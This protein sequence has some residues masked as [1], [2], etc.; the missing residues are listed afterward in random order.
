MLQLEISLNNSGQTKNQLPL[1]EVVMI[2]V[3]LEL[4]NYWEERAMKKDRKT[5]RKN[6]KFGKTMIKMNIMKFNRTQP[7]VEMDMN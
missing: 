3:K 4:N 1:K 2:H 7:L 5:K 6:L